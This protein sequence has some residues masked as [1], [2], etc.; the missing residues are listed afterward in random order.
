[1]AKA[2]VTRELAHLIEMAKYEYE[3]KPFRMRYIIGTAINNYPKV[4]NF[5]EQPNAFKVI[6]QALDEGYIIIPEKKKFSPSEA[7]D[8]L[9]NNQGR[10][11][12]NE[13]N[14]HYYM[15]KNNELLSSK[16]IGGYMDRSYINPTVWNNS[17]F[18]E[19]R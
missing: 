14:R 11:L 10:I 1:M 3:T 6:E 9:F 2:L 8:F 13:S 17:V 7:R 19:V 12:Y 5:M 15:V 18:T 16:N 4:V